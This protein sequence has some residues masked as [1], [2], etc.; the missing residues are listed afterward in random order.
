MSSSRAHTRL[1]GPLPSIA[2]TILAASPAT[3]AVAVASRADAGLP[4]E[5][6]VRREQLVTASHL[7][8]GFVPVDRQRLTPIA[9]GPEVAGEHGD[10]RRDL[11]DVHNAG[12]P[13]RR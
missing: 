4:C 3:S 5:R 1:T 13:H 8:A 10:A 2:F 9:R 7:G 11:H 6:T 12:H